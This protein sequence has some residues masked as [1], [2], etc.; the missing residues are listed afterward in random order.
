MSTT[1]HG[2]HLNRAKNALYVIVF[3]SG[4]VLMGLEIAGARILAPG[5][6]TS[7]YVWGSIIGLFMGALAAGYFFGGRLA[8]K[9]PSFKVLALIVSVA[10]I[11]IAILPWFGP[12]FSNKMAATNFPNFVG[13]LLTSAGLFLI[14]STLM[15]M[16]SPYA[17]KLSTSSLAGVGG[18]SGNMAALSTFGSIVGTLLT[19]FV[20]LSYWNLSSVLQ[21][22]GLL[23]L[24]T[25][26]ACM[27]VFNSAAN[28]VTR[29]ESTTVGLLALVALTG[30]LGSIAFP[31]EPP[32]YKGQ[33]N[34]LIE[35]SPYHDILV[36]EEFM[37]SYDDD[38]KNG[39]QLIPVNHW[40]NSIHEIRRWL[41][42][43]ENIE[44]GTYPYRSEHKNA[45]SYTDILHLPLIWVPQ[46]KRM[47]VVGGGG[48][49]IPSQYANWYG[50]EVDIAELDEKVGEVAQE[51][52]DMPY[53]NGK[54]SPKIKF[55]YG[56]GRR[57]ARSLKGPYDIILLDAYSSGGQ[58]PFHLMTWQFLNEMKAKLSENGVLVTNIITGLR[59]NPATGTAHNA[60]L[61]LAEYNT[62]RASRAQALRLNSDKPEDKAPL[63]STLYIFPKIYAGEG[64]FTPGNLAQYRNVIVIATNEAKQRTTDEIEQAAQELS[65]PDPDDDRDESQ[66]R[67]IF[68]KDPKVKCDLFPLAHNHR[69]FK[70]TGIPTEAE[71]KGVG[72]D[73][74][75]DDFAPVDRMYRPVK[76]DESMRRIR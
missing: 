6:G 22:L 25:A 47:L 41:K 75:T 63:F 20:L 18:S 30:V 50:T 58:I 15:A 60:D 71:T 1:P 62:L 43:N 42:F 19:T 39:G 4:A 59:G 16:V 33:R 45:V 65:A 5:F 8:D 26:V 73:V 3:I 72:V 24:I 68:P 34:I 38:D 29:S 61:F 54:L 37:W 9:H 67:K 32:R 44:S 11:W 76:K 69:L 49:I 28:L 52:F 35:D 14:P 13:P 7:T 10:A 2:M 56:D 23:L 70:Q 27:V 53:E 40:K 48:G 55:H 64:G 66:S 51:Y 12:E 17:I 57:T 36:T 74:M 31:V 46:P 21:V